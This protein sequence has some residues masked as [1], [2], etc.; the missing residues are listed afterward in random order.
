M[1]ARGAALDGLRILSPWKGG[2]VESE[3]RPFSPTPAGAE[4]RAD[5]RI[6]AANLR[7]E[8]PYRLS[9]SSVLAL[10]DRQGSSPTDTRAQEVSFRQFMRVRDGVGFPLAHLIANIEQLDLP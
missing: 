4:A 3:S 6:C 7:P 10:E 2:F 5:P 8:T 9:E 1:P